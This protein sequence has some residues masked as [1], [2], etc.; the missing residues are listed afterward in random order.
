LEFKNALFW[1]FWGVG[2]APALR[3]CNYCGYFSLNWGGFSLFK[4]NLP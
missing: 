1:G 4:A 3:A 2:G